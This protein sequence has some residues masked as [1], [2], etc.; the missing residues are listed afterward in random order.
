MRYDIFSNGVKVNTII[1]D[2]EFCEQYCGVNGYTFSLV[3]EPEPE[4]EPEVNVEP[5]PTVE[6]RI[7]QLE[8]EL[9]ELKSSLEQ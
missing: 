2:E 3:P 8:A 9:S 4:P 6:E 7:A 1:A 5:T